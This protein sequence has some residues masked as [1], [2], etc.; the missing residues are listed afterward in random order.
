MQ[1]AF[2]MDPIEHDKP[3]MYQGLSHQFY[4]PT[5]DVPFVSEADGIDF[6]GEFGVVVDEVPMGTRSEDAM[7]HIRLLRADQ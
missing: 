3:L 5:D 2:K 6:E 7:R 4:G 1:R